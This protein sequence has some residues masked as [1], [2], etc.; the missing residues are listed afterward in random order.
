[1]SSCKIVG[2]PFLCVSVYVGVTYVEE[3]GKVFEFFFSGVC[4]EFDLNVGTPVPSYNSFSEPELTL[5]TLQNFF[6]AD[7]S[8][9]HS[10][11]FI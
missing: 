5:L 11:S 6:K 1:M 2:K 4:E 3:E 7:T 8:F 9:S 10:P